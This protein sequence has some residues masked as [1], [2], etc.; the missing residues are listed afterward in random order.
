[1]REQCQTFPTSRIEVFQDLMKH[2]KFELLKANLWFLLFSFVSFGL[3]YFYFLYSGVVQVSVQ[4]GSLTLPSN[5]NG[6]V[7][8][9]DEYLLGFRTILFSVLI[10]TNIPLFLG[11]GGLQKV[12]Q[13]LIFAEPIDKVRIVFFEG[14]KKNA[15]QYIAL[16]II[17]S[18]I[19][20]FAQ[21]M[22][23]FYFLYAQ[24]FVG[25]ICIA[26]SIMLLILLNHFIPFAL[27]TSNLYKMSF[28]GLIKNSYGLYFARWLRNI[29]LTW[30]VSIPVA[31]FLIPSTYFVSIWFFIF[32]MLYM[33]LALIVM[34]LSFNEVCDD[35]INKTQFPEIYRKGL[36][37]KKNAENEWFNRDI[38]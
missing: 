10:I 3:L 20:D 22:L 6:E 29:P 19:I 17:F 26:I 4:D 30:L 15:K 34:T 37:D 16:S 27:P 18:V 2:H 31:L 14:L 28:F 24:D 1:M 33:P 25:I 5:A 9:V 21:F 8:T 35:K 23:S 38:I 11:L 12:V 32:L 13:T 7:M 36:F